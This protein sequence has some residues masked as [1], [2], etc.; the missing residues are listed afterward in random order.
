MAPTN[1]TVFVLFFAFAIGFFGGL[2]SLTPPAFVSWAGHWGWL[3]FGA[4]F[5]WAG[6]LPA[7]LVFTLAAVAELIADKLPKAP[8]RTAALGLGARVI[9]GGL[10]GAAVATNGG[11]GWLPGAMAGIVGGLAGCFLG[12]LVRTRLSKAL[13][14]DLPVALAEDLIAIFG[15]LWVVLHFRL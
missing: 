7:A 11:A 13:G 12:F 3:K 9:V 10:C 1:A 8:N 2:R 14:R 15:S 6:T 5:S 4:L